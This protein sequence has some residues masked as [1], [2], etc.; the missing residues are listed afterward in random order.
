MDVCHCLVRAAA[1]AGQRLM[2]ERAAA[3]R[4]GRLVLA[5]RP[6]QGGAHGELRLVTEGEPMPPGFSVSAA[7]VLKIDVPYER[8]Y[9]WVRER[10]LRLPILGAR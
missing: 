2:Q 1:D 8:Y 7:D 10:S 9:A 5:W 3:G 4:A 6:S